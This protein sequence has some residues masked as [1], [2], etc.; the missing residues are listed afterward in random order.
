MI[1]LF[2]GENTFALARELQTVSRQFR[3]TNGAESVITRGGTDLTL[4]DLPQLLQGMSLFTTQNLV[5]IRDASANKAL[6]EG[7]ADFLET[8]SDCDLIIAESK[9]DKRTRTF[10]WLQK[11]AE[12]K[13]FKPL[14][15]AELMVWCQQESKVVGCDL[16]PQLARTLVA[17]AGSDQWQLA[18]NIKK[19]ALAGKPVTEDLITTII[20]PHPEVS[21]FALLDTMLRGQRDT[22]LKLLSDIRLTED[23]Y[24]FMGL[25]ISQ[26]YTLA[27]CVY[28]RGKS[29]PDIAR[30]A[31]LHPYVVQK[32]SA[33]ARQIDAKRLRELLSAAKNCD[34]RLKS[35]AS[36]PWLVVETMIGKL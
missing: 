3:Q 7:L 27:L 5:V 30:E 36:E 25:Y 12:T 21:V 23:P 11:H 26:L 14:N 31:S 17:H 10:K 29:S 33:L 16:T 24:K 15:E 18:N 28:A 6:W 34:Y 2:Y 8:R 35:S 19:L 4:A 20:E 22:A 1:R 13:E 32:M 9:P